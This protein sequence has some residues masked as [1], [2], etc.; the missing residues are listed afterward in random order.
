M[1][2]SA[3]C[4][5]GI[6]DQHNAI[7]GVAEQLS[8]S[9]CRM[10]YFES[11]GALSLTFL[12][13][14]PAIFALPLPMNEYAIIFDAGSS[15]TKMEI[16]KIN[17]QDA[18]LDVNDVVQ[19]DLSPNKVKPGIASLAD[20]PSGVEAYMKPLL[21]LAKKTIS[22]ERQATTPILFLA[23]AGMR[24]L[25]KDKSSAI[26]AKVRSLFKDKTKCP[27]QFI[28][29]QNARIITGKW[30]AIYSWITVNFL[31]KVFL[32][33]ETN[34]TY[35]ILDLGGASHQY[36]MDK[37]TN[38]PHVVFINIGGKEYSLLV[39][40][41]LGYGLNEARARYMRTID[42][43]KYGAVC[44]LKSP[45][46]HVGYSESIMT[47]GFRKTVVG[48]ANVQLCRS[49]I[50]S[51]FFC[52]EQNF[53]KCP[54]HKQ[55]NLKGKVYGFSGIFYVLRGIGALCGDCTESFVT[56]KELDNK[57]LIYCLRKYSEI[58]SDPYAKGNCFGGNF[59]YELLKHGYR[60]SGDQGI[61]VTNRLHGFD[62]GWTMGAL[63]YNLNLL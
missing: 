49:F 16:Y 12:W 36:A 19:V 34:E 5:Y 28:H 2:S 46:H 39:R 44:Q 6:P 10:K 9:C 26:M 54:M 45:C 60:L 29:P 13:L 17:K 48:T 24:L 30:E 47:N 62:L 38:R 56:S 25:S 18:I 41:Y 61:T 8:L 14:F 1:S 4:Q 37:R 22:A 7:I 43:C 23:T 57:T 55:P 40:S 42:N 52:Q 15:K 27:F 53:D 50:R 59:I 21:D 58:S 33:H 31:K 11:P 32:P 3:S 51:I 20:N 35:G 63:L